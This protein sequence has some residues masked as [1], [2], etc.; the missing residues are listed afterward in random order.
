MM[1]TS[2]RK[3]ITGVVSVTSGCLGVVYVVWLLRTSVDDFD[4]GLRFRDAF[5][6]L[7]HGD[8]CSLGRRVLARGHPRRYSQE[9]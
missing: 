9:S 8:G 3:R 6:L 4:D 1:A 5:N 2:V 7:L